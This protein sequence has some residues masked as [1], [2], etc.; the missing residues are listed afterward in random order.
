ME[1]YLSLVSFLPPGKEPTE[2][3]N[4]RLKVDQSYNILDLQFID[5]LNV[6]TIK[7]DEEK[8]GGKE[9]NST[10]KF[11]IKNVYIII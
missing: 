5:K 4:K 2:S 9:D 7:G 3:Y 11:K 8:K 6:Y 10:I 1:A